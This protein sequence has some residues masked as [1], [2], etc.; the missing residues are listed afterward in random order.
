MEEQTRTEEPINAE[1][2]PETLEA[3]AADD[4]SNALA[5]VEEYKQALQ[6]E[7]ADFQNFRKRIEREMDELRAKTSGDVLLKLLPVVDDFERALNAV[8]DEQKSTDWVGGMS[9]I[10]RKLQSLLDAEGVKSIDPL[11]EEFNPSF[12]EAI[13]MDEPTDTY[14][15]GHVTA[16][17]QRGYLKGERVLRPAMVRV[18]N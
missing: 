13:G 17:L 4:L 3:T 12:H 16:V 8:P 14:A 5:Q 15:S 9:L 18:A 11:G 1:D 6:R 7:R 10:Q 2:S